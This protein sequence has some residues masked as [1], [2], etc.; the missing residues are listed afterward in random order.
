MRLARSH[1][2]RALLLSV[3]FYISI[4]EPYNMLAVAGL[5]EEMGIQ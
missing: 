3:E 5:E 1:V 4:L 2:R